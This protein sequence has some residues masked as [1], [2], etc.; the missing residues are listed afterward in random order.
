[1]MKEK[2]V[3]LGAGE[4]GIGAAILGKHKGYDVFLSD[5]NTI[6]VSLQ[7]LLNEKGILW[8]SGQHSIASMKD[9]TIAIKSPG[10]P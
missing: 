10:I 1:M 3:V 2:L 5:K 6:P 7:K 9:A 8:E 4:S